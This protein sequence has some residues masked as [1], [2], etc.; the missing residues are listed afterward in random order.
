MPLYYS[1]KQLRTFVFAGV[2]CASTLFLFAEDKIKIQQ[3]TQIDGSRALSV[4]THKANDMIGASVQ[5]KSGEKLGTVRDLAFEMP[6]GKLGYVIVA[7]GGIL[8]LGADFHAVPPKVFSHETTSARL[9]TLDM[10]KERWESSPKF[11]K[12]Q[13]TGLNAHSQQIDKHFAEAGQEDLKAQAKIGDA[14]AE[15]KIKTPDINAAAKSD[16]KS[17]PLRLASDLIGKQV[18]TQQNEEVGKISDLLVDMKSTKVAFAIISAGT[19][20][21]PS[22]ARYAVATQNLSMG[23]EKN[24]IMLN[25]DRNA[26]EKAEVFDAEK[27]QAS[28]STSGTAGIFKYE[29]NDATVKAEIDTDDTKKSSAEARTSI[30][31]PKPALALINEGNRYVGEQA[32]DKVVQIRSEKSIN[33]LMPNVWYVVY[34][35]PTAALKATEVKFYNGQMVDVKRPLRLL[36][37]TSNKAEPLDR[38]KIKLDSDKAVETALKERVFENVKPTASQLRLERGPGGMPIWQVELWAAKANDSKDDVNLGTVTLS[39]EDGK[40]IK[41][42][43]KSER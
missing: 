6:S 3:D 38:S 14:K 27:W 28:G 35:D 8:G 17:E 19:L 25:A 9:L 32:K 29:V 15:V 40:V 42:D 2:L 13:L 37:A 23:T 18:V 39:A 24:K 20:L 41:T 21:K 36:E 30:G 16:A 7:S 10:T 31:S 5:N 26:L 11:K 4:T 1:M 22:E 33:G 43:L 34:Y 12:D